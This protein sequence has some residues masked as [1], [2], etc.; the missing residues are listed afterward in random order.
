MYLIRLHPI[1]YHSQS[2]TIHIHIHK[3]SFSHYMTTL[4]SNDIYKVKAVKEVPTK[5][6]QFMGSSIKSYNLL[7]PVQFHHNILSLLLIGQNLSFQSVK[8]YLFYCPFVRV[9]QD[10]CIVCFRLGYPKTINIFLWFVQASII[11]FH[12]FKYQTCI[13]FREKPINLWG[14]NEGS[15]DFFYSCENKKM[16]SRV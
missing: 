2:K 3:L 15:L 13:L 14:G 4:L 9:H 10:S 7:F 11:Y 12:S 6:K 1:I 16:N 8:I 5:N